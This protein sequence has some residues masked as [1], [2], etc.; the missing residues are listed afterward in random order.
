MHL[1]FADRCLSF[2]VTRIK[3]KCAD[4]YHST[5]RIHGRSVE[6]GREFSNAIRPIN[7]ANIGDEIHFGGFDEQE[8]CDS[9][10]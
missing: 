4:C 5:I 3:A 10:R 8:Q 7:S 6:R 9:V 2:I 1:T